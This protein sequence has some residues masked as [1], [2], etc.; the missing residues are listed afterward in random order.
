MRRVALLMALVVGCGGGSEKRAGQ[1]ALP[2]PPDPKLDKP[3]VAFRQPSLVIDR[4][5]TPMPAP[6]TVGSQPSPVTME[7]DAPEVVSV[8]AT[9][10]LVAHRA[11]SAKVRPIGTGGAALSVEVRPV[12]VIAIVP[13]RISIA[14]GGETRVRLV[15]GGS[16]EAVPAKS[17]QWLTTDPG[18]AFVDGGTLRAGKRIGKARIVARY[19]GQEASAEVL[20]GVKPRKAAPVDVARSSKDGSRQGEAR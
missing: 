13:P 20:V 14:P 17:V 3:F 9:G 6:V 19:G 10:A 7:S 16:G 4:L 5:E 1:P 8:D 12:S 11:G 2:P 18:I 15:A